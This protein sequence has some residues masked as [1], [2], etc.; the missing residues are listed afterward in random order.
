MLHVIA[1]M[2]SLLLLA[3]LFGNGLDA[4]DEESATP[5]GECVVNDTLTHA[6]ES[7]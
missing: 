2:L 1:A 3:G 4:T 5:S 7:A 6:T